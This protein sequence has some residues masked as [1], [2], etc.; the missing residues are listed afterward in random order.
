M[1]RVALADLDAVTL[2]AFGTLLE[3]RYPVPAL[4][5]A[6]AERGVERDERAVR[7]AFEVEAEYYRAHRLQA[8]DDETLAQL[9]ERCGE[10]FLAAVGAP[11]L[12]FDYGG[13]FEFTVIDGVP[14]AVE[15][16]AR[17]GLALAVVAD[18]DIGLAQRLH[19]RG[20]DR[21]LATVVTAA[22][23]GA[24]KPST[25][26]F[27]LALD[28]L[29]VEP[30]RALHVGDQPRDAEGA[31]AAGMHFERAPLSDVLERLS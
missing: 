6:L 14:D 23:V 29:R 30:N 13:F 28:R 19:D 22:E 4:R 7:E 16:L 18:W 24:V 5:Q 27:R 12:A 9:Y 25:A 31:A 21:H 11:G 26:G 2:D 15:R 17:H 1:G 8:R 10:T 20:L 3:L